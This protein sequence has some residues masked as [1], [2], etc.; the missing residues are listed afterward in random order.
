M[1]KIYCKI[2]NGFVVDRIVFGPEGIP[3]NW[4]DHDKMV[5]EEVAQIG[6]YFSEGVFTPPLP[7]VPEFPAT[8][9]PNLE[10]DQFWFIVR[11]TNHEQELRAWID[12]LDPQTRAYAS[13][14]LEFAKFY[15]RDNEFV[16]MARI[17]LGLSSEELDTLW[18]YA[19]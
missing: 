7:P 13:S 2:E 14:K 19:L 5:N 1:E 6:W 17:A 16:E 9:L 4:P 3:E 11:L 8:R 18:S 15:E 10:P 12:D